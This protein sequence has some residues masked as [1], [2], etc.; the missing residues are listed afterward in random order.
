MN[1]TFVEWNQFL[2]GQEK[3]KIEDSY[4]EAESSWETYSSD[5]NNRQKLLDD[6][7][8]KWNTYETLSQSLDVW[9][10]E[11]E[12]LIEKSKLSVCKVNLN[13]ISLITLPFFI[14]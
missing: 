6:L 13:V 9:M 14:L 1:R 3:I 4:R 2:L 11:A 7:T 10:Q 8:K 5:C 12:R